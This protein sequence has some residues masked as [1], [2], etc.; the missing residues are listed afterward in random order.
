MAVG[1]DSLEDVFLNTE[2]VEK[3]V[4]DLVGASGCLSSALSCVN[5]LNKVVPA[6][7]ND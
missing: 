2:V 4:G 6:A 5:C 7:Q 1:S 3:V